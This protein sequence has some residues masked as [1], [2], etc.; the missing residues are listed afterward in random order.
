M[1][2]KFW[3]GTNNI[4]LLFDESRS[5]PDSLKKVTKIRFFFLHDFFISEVSSSEHDMKI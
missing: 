3:L 1:R 5:T 2:G 4:S